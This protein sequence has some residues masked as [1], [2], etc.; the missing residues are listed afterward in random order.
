MEGLGRHL[1]CRDDRKHCRN[2]YGF[3][4]CRARPLEVCGHLGVPLLQDRYLGRSSRNSCWIS[5]YKARV[6][7]TTDY[8]LI[9]EQYKRSKQLPWRTHVEAFGLMTAIG[10]PAGKAV[11][12]IACGDGLYSRMIR[13]RGAAKVTVSIFPKR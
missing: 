13:R 7:L 10:D 5:E 4:A 9:A 3:R 1:R 12:D 2:R 11:I 8:D 6:T